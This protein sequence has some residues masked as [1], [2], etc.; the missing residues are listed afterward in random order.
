M[1]TKQVDVCLTFDFDAVSVW[2]GTFKAKSPSAV[3]RGEFGAVAVPRI[4][5]LLRRFD[6]PSTWCT[7]GHTADTYPD[8]VRRVADG[9][10]EIAHHGYCHENPT[11]LSL[12]QEKRVLDKGI[13]AL[14]RI[15]GQAPEGY[16]SPAW[17]LTEHSIDLLLERGF[18]YDSSLMGN[19]YSP[20]YCR[21]G[22]QPNTEGPYIFG[23]PVD[24]V[25]IP[26]TWSLDD[27]PP[28]EFV[29]GMNA[30]LTGV[31]QV[32]EN[33]RG[34]FEYLYERIGSGVFCLTMHP[35]VIGR[36]H[37]MLMLERLMRT[38]AELPGVRFRTMA[39]VARDWRAANPLPQAKPRIAAAGE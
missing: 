18:S 33:W 28:F 22:D 34:D 39:D 29:I 25:E 13:A 11:T 5:D 6:A 12:D 10:H 24:L 31:S 3:S 37:R 9:G 19:D 2:L 26:V 14:R 36:G 8:L 16:R 7:P 20:Y 4:L 21:T 15:T 1:T 23:D 35:Q 27:F 30:G 38:M 17:D 32:E